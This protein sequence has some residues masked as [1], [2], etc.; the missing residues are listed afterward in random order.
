MPYCG[1][2][3][4]VHHDMGHHRRE[5]C[6]RL[7]FLWDRLRCKSTELTL[8]SADFVAPLLTQRVTMLISASMLDM[9]RTIM[10]V[11]HW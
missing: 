3:Q 2:A 10:S 11:R 6:E 7:V 4:F 8:L 5:T 1:E 9:R